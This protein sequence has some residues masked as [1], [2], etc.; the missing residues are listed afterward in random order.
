MPITNQ[1]TPMVARL[2]GTMRISSRI[3]GNPNQRHQR[4]RNTERQDHLRQDQQ[5]RRLETKSQQDQCRYCRQ[6][7]TPNDRNTAP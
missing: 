5:P 1:A 2:V 6:Q 3:S 7:P 4:K